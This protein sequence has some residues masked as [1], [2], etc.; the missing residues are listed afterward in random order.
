[1]KDVFKGM[2][3]VGA[4][5]QL[6]VIAFD[7]KKKLAEQIAEAVEGFVLRDG[8]YYKVG[9]SMW[10]NST[11]DEF[12]R[13]GQTIG[14]DAKGELYRFFVGDALSFGEDTVTCQ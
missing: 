7:G 1:M 4:F 10:K 13:A 9:V 2:H 12:L 11:G 14:I 3:S 5:I 8:N 6:R